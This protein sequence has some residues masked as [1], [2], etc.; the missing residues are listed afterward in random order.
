M[1]E[2]GAVVRALTSGPAR[3]LGM[4][5]PDDVI[6]VDPSLEWTVTADALVS[7]G[8][9]TPLLGRRLRGRVVAVAMDGGIRY[10]DADALARRSG[11]E[12]VARG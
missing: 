7:K 8:K 12:A 11:A 1:G 10:Q 6:V 5:G 4:R 3:V 2:L 9:N